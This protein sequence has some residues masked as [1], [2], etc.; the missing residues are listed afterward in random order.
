M[1]DTAK[2]K[3]S[4][5]TETWDKFESTLAPTRRAENYDDTRQTDK[6]QE[7]GLSHKDPNKFIPNY[8]TA[9]SGWKNYTPRI[10][11]P[12]TPDIK[13]M[14]YSSP[15]NTIFDMFPYNTL[16]VAF[17]HIKGCLM[18]IKELKSTSF[19]S[20]DDV[21]CDK[22]QTLITKLEHLQSKGDSIELSSEL[23]HQKIQIVPP[24]NNFRSLSLYPTEEEILR[25]ERPQLKPNRIRERYNNVEDYLDVQFRLL[26]EDFLRPLR[27]GINFYKNT[28]TKMKSRDSS[29]RIYSNVH[30]ERSTG[31][32]MDEIVEGE[33]VKKPVLKFIQGTK[34]KFI[35]SSKSKLNRIDWKSSKRLMH[36]SLVCFT[37]NNFK[38][39]LLATVRD[40]SFKHLSKGF[41]YVDFCE[42]YNENIYNSTYMMFESEV[43]FEPYYHVLKT[44]QNLYSFSFPMS[45][46]LVSA[47]P[48]SYLPNYSAMPNKAENVMYVL[49]GVDSSFQVTLLE[50]S[51]WPTPAQMGLDPSQ[52]VALQAGLTQE[53]AVI[54]G[55]PGT[56]KTFIGLKIAQILLS[57]PQNSYRRG[58]I[59]IVC[60]TNHAL[61]QFLEGIVNFT[62]KLIRVGGQSKSDEIE[63]YNIKH[64]R[65]YSR[66]EMELILPLREQIENCQSQMAEIGNFIDFIFGPKVNAIA[67]MTT[68]Q[69]YDIPLLSN[70]AASSLQG[71]L[72]LEWLGIELPENAINDEKTDQRLKLELTIPELKTIITQL[73][74]Q[75][76]QE[77]A[78]KLLKN[79]L[80]ALKRVLDTMQKYLEVMDMVP[81]ANEVSELLSSV[82]EDVW[83]ISQEKRWGLYWF[84]VQQL[85]WKLE[86]KLKELRSHQQFLQ[87]RLENVKH[88]VEVKIMASS[89]VVGMTTAGGAR[90]HEELQQ[91]EPE[92]L[93]VEEAAEVLESH[94]IA[95]LTKSCKHLILIGDHKQLRPANSVYQLAREYDLDVSLFERMVRTQGGC[96]T[97][98]VQHRMSPCIATLLTPSIYSNL[99]NHPCVEQLPPVLGIPNRLYFI[100]HEN[101]EEQDSETSSYKN[102][103][104]GQYVIA[105]CDYLISQ[106]Y[107]LTQITILTTYSA[108]MIYIHREIRANHPTLQGLRVTV[109]DNFQ[110]EENDIILLSL[111]RS[112]LEG[113]IGFLST[114]NRV[115]V[116][117]SRAKHGFYIVGNMK[118]L[119]SGS[120]LWQA[121]QANLENQ[122]AIGPALPI[123]CQ[124][125]EHMNSLIKEPTEFGDV[126]PLGGCRIFCEGT[127]PCGHPCNRSCHIK[128]HE[129]LQCDFPCDRLCPMGHPCSN[130]CF[131]K[132]SCAVAT[133][134]VLPTC[135]HTVQIPCCEKP[136]DIV[137]TAP[138]D[139]TLPCGHKCPRKCHVELDPKHKLT[140]CKE[141]CSQVC[142]GCEFNHPCTKKCFQPCGQCAVKMK[143]VRSCGHSVET[144]CGG[145]A[146]AIPC[147]EIIIEKLDCGHEGTRKCSETAKACI[148]PVKKRIPDCGHIINVSCK[149]QPR[150]ELCY[151]KCERQLACGHICEEKCG[152]SCTTRC[153]KPVPTTKWRPCLH[154]DTILCWE[155]TEGVVTS[156]AAN[157]CQVPCAYAMLCGHNCEGTCSSC[158]QGKIHISCSKP[159]SR[160]LVCGHKCPAMCSD[161]CAPCIQPCTY[162]CPHGSCQGR[163]GEPCQPCQYRCSRV[164]RHHQCP[165]KC[166]EFCVVPPCKQPCP[167]LLACHHPCMGICGDPCPPICQVCDSGGVQKYIMG[168]APPE[169]CRF[170]LLPSCGHIIESSALEQWTTDEYS[171]GVSLRTCPICLTPLSRVPRYQGRVKKAYKG[172]VQVTNKM[173]GDHTTNLERESL[174]QSISM[175]ISRVQ[176]RTL[177]PEFKPL[178]NALLSLHESLQTKSEWDRIPLGNLLM[179][180]IQYCVLS[181]CDNIWDNCHSYCSSTSKKELLCAAMTEFLDALEDV[182]SH[183]GQQQVR[184]FTLETY[185]LQRVSQLEM[186]KENLAICPMLEPLYEELKSLVAGVPKRYSKHQEL[187]IKQTFLDVHKLL[188]ATPAAR[189]IREVMMIPLPEAPNLS[190]GRWFQCYILNK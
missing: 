74:A 8:K 181:N 132:C 85:C 144:T 116:A 118:C 124:N 46:Y 24:P 20:I 128:S 69:K 149:E 167:L 182:K 43:Y 11:H 157:R 136:E 78:N 44:L 106:G 22:F 88:K 133:E 152:K 150:R 84:W 73:S 34:V 138:C 148:Q 185:R 142:Q 164:C 12:L 131:E 95:C 70:V 51:T 166:S 174:A 23:F 123:R 87:E 102:I 9:Q 14:A 107:E 159:C 117:L 119:S 108:Q 180:K 64:K 147:M 65:R 179:M 169:N 27:E 172:I 134:V 115:C 112:N 82:T 63:I 10:T 93:I 98:G 92:I 19:I 153:V 122:N 176:H 57:P 100:N 38:T 190:K 99:E 48:D 127:L 151:E 6:F 77:R 189:A 54:Q 18:C 187:K 68:M 186:V 86:S 17:L 168:H 1:A 61:D 90:L 42:K 37:C 15:E 145:N 32:E 161:P 60:F 59:L 41:V 39:L 109:V 178:M 160:N 183:L 170:L 139:F 76:E 33:N 16:E 125:H 56:G 121:M 113:K 175:L 129:E 154:V 75:T 2:E 71:L 67:S 55:P 80:S 62:S 28:G 171:M 79:R 158:R 31:W 165:K 114:Q 21:C 173:L 111:V 13:K 91:M 30:F 45:K 81:Q 110:G 155:S 49:Q 40:R 58:P 53:L 89:D 141:P 140:K 50:E 156:S 101:M 97:L 47:C 3:K 4:P 66:W 29:V 184:D 105:L 146:D 36:N 25:N 7:I 94:I 137:C 130:P 143:K 162:C 177:V 135:K 188:Q 83:K 103:Y 126:S 104:E 5:T 163:C 35:N 52:L 72:L 26:R 120:R 96:V